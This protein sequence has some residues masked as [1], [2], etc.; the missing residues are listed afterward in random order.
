[1]TLKDDWGTGDTY[2]A[3]DMNALTTQV[4]ENTAVLT[5]TGLAGAGSPAEARAAIGASVPFFDARDYGVIADGAEHNNVANLL[6]CFAACEAAGGGTVLLPAGTIVTSDA[7]AWVTVTANS[8][9][10]Y[11]NRGG[12]P[13]P[14]NTP[15]TV[16]GQG[17]GA[18]VLK[19][20]AGFPRLFDLPQ[21]SLSTPLDIRDITLRDFT[22][23]QDSLTGLDL[24]PLTKVTGNVTIPA[25]G[26][27]VTLPGVSAAT[28]KNCRL[29]W[30]METNS[31]TSAGR[32]FPARVSAGNFQVRNDSGTSYTVVTGDDV[33][34]SWR[35]HVI[36]GNYIDAGSVASGR[37]TRVD[38][39]L[40]ER[41]DTINVSTGHSTTGIVTPNQ[42]DVIGN[43]R[44]FMSY[45]G[46]TA[47]DMVPS[48]TRCYTKDC[49]FEGGN[50][51]VEFNG[52]TGCW[53][54]DVWC[55]DT[56]HDTMRDVDG[57]SL[58]AN[59]HFAQYAWMGKGGVIRCTG[60]RS[61]DV[62]LEVDQP[63][64]FYE[65]DCVWDEA[66]NGV[67]STTFAPPAR[68]S[69]GPPT[70]TLGT[71]ISGTWDGSSPITPTFT[72]WPSEV[73]RAGVLLID[74]ELF[75]YTTPDNTGNA[76]SLMRALNGSTVAA[77][78]TGATVTFVEVE[79]TRIYSIRSTTRSYDTPAA[80]TGG[81][82]FVSYENSR[83]PL[84]PLTI[85]DANV[86]M[87]GG[88]F[89]ASGRLL[90]QG[91]WR[92]DLEMTG[93]RFNHIG[94]TGPGA[95]SNIFGNT[96]Y[97]QWLAG[98][99]I[100]SLYPISPPRIYGRDNFIRL[101]GVALSNKEYYEAFRFYRGYAL[102]DFDLETDIA[103]N[104]VGSSRIRSM[105]LQ[106]EG[107]SVV[108]LARGS[109]V[110]VKH[111]ASSGVGSD[112]F[113]YALMLGD[114]SL[115]I[116]ADTLTVDIDATG[117]DFTT[118]ANDPWY[119]PW[120][121]GDDTNAAKVVFG[122]IVHSAS[123]TSSYP[124]QK[125]PTIRVTS[126]YDVLGHDS[127]IQVDTTG[128][129]VEITLPRLTGGSLSI[130]KR[131]LAEGQHITIVD[132]GFNS[133]T[134]AITVTPHASDAINEGSSG[135]SVTITNDGD[136]LV[137]IAHPAG[138]GWVTQSVPGSATPTV[139]SLL[140]TNGTTAVSVDAVA[141]AVNYLRV[142]PNVSTQPV[143]VRAAGGDTNVGL[144]VRP[145]GTGNV[146]MLDGNGWPIATFNDWGAVGA[147]GNYWI[148]SAGASGSSAL[149]LSAAGGDT[150]V[151][152]NVLTKGAGTL[153]ANGS[154]VGVKVAVPASAG[155]TGVPGQWAAD[156]NY[157]YACTA[158]NTWVRC[159][160][161]AW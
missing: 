114:S 84:P 160:T 69:A 125:V 146:R 104:G 119:M 59:F 99:T 118:A 10:T 78:T 42:A 143:V 48:L 47:D 1:M 27:Y 144:S 22:V 53:V 75:W 117:M 95:V 41:V 112:L 116:I 148:F 115:L 140:A 54:D 101:H 37:N 24:L 36:I 152:I 88:D 76:V 134:N 67:Y 18:T 122:E 155:A 38:N 5:D 43:V 97:V 157:I 77:H 17:R 71:D 50:T 102:L 13:L 39:L 158:T 92:P 4:N 57:N 120:R 70:A 83:L 26:T 131:D 52:G 33:R 40:I 2:N 51:G 73:S 139:S 64:V 56:F 127:V 130:G 132:V 46:L 135:S 85:H 107:A 20:S 63:W 11:T 45:S 150:N 138:P 106:G 103:I 142:Y 149:N 8:G 44:L 156:A 90:Y 129:P 74:S 25:G 82:A 6:D 34:G 153:Q 62:A 14:L 124:Q 93:T 111:K 154:P 60:R 15:I 28:F 110:G 12:I 86:D 29:V 151:S 55:I 137:L 113:S 89:T 136:S 96:V 141:S 31:G 128:G 3:D 72:S 16:A 80:S 108:S 123:A 126:D 7:D 21:P 161:D 159:A 145:K 133:G 35:N 19:L 147:D 109:R 49:R 30:F 61:A 9:N 58:C 65:V 81:R 121:I 105:S 98:G 32:L 91:G 23:D 100:S 94:A 87:H 68:T 66:Y 79:K